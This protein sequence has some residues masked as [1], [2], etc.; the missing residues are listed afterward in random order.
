MAEYDQKT[1]RRLQLTLLDMVKDIDEVC[2]KNNINYYIAYGSTL[3]AVRH[4]GF[5]PWDDD[6]DICVCREDYER[7]FEC[8][9]KEFGD[10]YDILNVK[11]TPKYAVA[12]YKISKKGT[13]FVE[14]RGAVDGY[15]QG[16]FIDVFPLDYTSSDENERRKL[17]KKEWFWSHLLILRS[18]KNPIVPNVYKG[19]RKIVVSIVCKCIYVIMS[20]L[21]INKMWIYNNFHKTAKSYTKDKE[22]MTDYCAMYTDRVLN[23]T[24]DLFPVKYVKFEDTEL[25]VP[26]NV[27][28]YLRKLYG[29]YMK[30]P[31]PEDRHNHF[32]SVIDFG[33]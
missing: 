28:V 2:R 29:D 4:Q 1:L 24:K 12:F 31:K 16:I 6:M 15:E 10:K 13:K 19:F 32:A 7:F 11:N 27:D 21:H 23:R 26:N 20:I 18:I 22:Y 33:D 25:P 3:G 30:L 5:I 17:I 8:I 9:K 14:M